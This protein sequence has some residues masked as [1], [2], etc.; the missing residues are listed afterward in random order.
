MELERE[1]LHPVAANKHRVALR[2]Q[3]RVASQVE[4]LDPLHLG[5]QEHW[6]RLLTI[7]GVL[8]SWRNALQLERLKQLVRAPP[9]NVA[10]V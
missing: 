1:L 4:I 8:R 7:R 3:L 5:D 9:I 2:G 6:Q 10:A